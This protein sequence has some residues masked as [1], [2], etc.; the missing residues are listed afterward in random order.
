[1]CCLQLGSAALLQSY[2]V[3]V[4]SSSSCTSRAGGFQS[5]QEGFINTL[6]DTTV[7]LCPGCKQL[8]VL[9]VACRGSTPFAKH[10]EPSLLHS[11]AEALPLLSELTVFGR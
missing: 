5:D 10:F 11:I 3:P 2:T 6:Q 8:R 9:D 4:G 1:M 7:I